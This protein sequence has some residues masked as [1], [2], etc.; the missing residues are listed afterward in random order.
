[1]PIVKIVI[2]EI[3]KLLDE[4]QEFTSEYLLNKP[5]D[6]EENGI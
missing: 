5:T 6:V 1:M 3:P 4:L 2:L